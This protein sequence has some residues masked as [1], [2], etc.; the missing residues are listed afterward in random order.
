M[1]MWIIYL[2]FQYKSKAQNFIAITWQTISQVFWH[3]PTA[4]ECA[5]EYAFMLVFTLIG[6]VIKAALQMVWLPIVGLLWWFNFY[7]NLIND[8]TGRPLWEILQSPGSGYPRS[9]GPTRS[10]HG[11]KRWKKNGQWFQQ[12]KLPFRAPC[13]PLENN[14]K[15]RHPKP[16]RKQFPGIKPLAPLPTCYLP[17]DHREN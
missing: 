16:F 13:F 9:V 8:P 14:R 1:L 11:V 15:R 3:G 5:S 2:P 6:L 10:R 4:F 17:M 7:K 12:T